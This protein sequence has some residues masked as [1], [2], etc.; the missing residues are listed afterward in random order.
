MPQ[1]RGFWPKRVALAAL[2]VIA[3]VN[4]WTGGPLLA[5]WLGSKVQS[6]SALSMGTVFVVIATLAAVEAVLAIAL[7]QLGALYD[8]VTDRPARPRQRA[9]W[10]RS[11][12]DERTHA[13]KHASELSALEKVMVASVV[14]AVVVLETWF[15][16]F[17]GS[18]LPRGG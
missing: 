15:F 17:A 5:L 1:R 18:S 3:G 9:T 2:M 11:L 12:R 10:L 14:L 4:L 6:G 8:S 13:E 16:F 7:T